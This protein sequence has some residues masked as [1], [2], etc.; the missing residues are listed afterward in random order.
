MVSSIEMGI[1]HMVMAEMKDIM[2]GNKNDLVAKAAATGVV[3]SVPRIHNMNDLT[4]KC[5]N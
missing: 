3:L 2:I 4:A 5:V 1:P